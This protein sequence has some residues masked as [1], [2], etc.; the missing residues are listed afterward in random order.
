[1]KQRRL[2]RLIRLSSNRFWRLLR[3]NRGALAATIIALILLTLVSRISVAYFLAND[4]PGDGIVYARLATN[5]LDHGTFSSDEEE[6]YSPTY[7]RMPGYPLF[8]AGIYYVFGHE[9]NTAVRISQAVVDT[10]TCVFAS[11]IAFAWAS[12]IRRRRAA[13]WAYIL[14]S[15]CPFIVIYTATILSETVATFFMAA[16]TLT[17]TLAIKSPRALRSAF[18]WILSGLLAG[19]SV[20]IRPDAGLFA[21]GIGVTLVVCGLFLRRPETPPFFHRLLDVAWKGAVFSLVFLLVLTPWTVRNWRLFG[22]FQ[23]LSPAHGEMPGEFVALGYDRWL[24]TWVDDSRFTEPML[25]NLDEKRIHLDSIP[26][27]AFDSPEEK[28]AVGALLDQYNYPPGTQKPKPADQDDNGDDDSDKSGDSD[29][30]SADD[31]GPDQQ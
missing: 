15:V 14:V 7:I 26:D 13:F 6:P 24:R 30:D 18:W 17:A 5:L 23:P 16:M 21:A 11:M 2:R 8:I 4:A 31:N 9:N 27:N 1:M 29:P 10:V 3:R 25:W 19:T 20:F 12:G 22:S 28:Q